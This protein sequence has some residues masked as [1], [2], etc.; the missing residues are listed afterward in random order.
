[1]GTLFLDEVAELPFHLQ[2]K[3]LRVLQEHSFERLGSVRPIEFTA[4]IVA[5]S[6]RNL[7]DEVSAGNFREDLYHRLNLAS[8]PVPALRERENDIELL[9]AHFLNQANQEIGKSVAGIELDVVARLNAY[10]WPGNVRELEH[11]IKRAVLAARG[12]TVTLHE[13]DLPEERERSASIN[14]DLQQSLRAQAVEMVADPGKF[15]GSGHVY[16][17]LMDAAGLELIHAALKS[18]NGNQV[19]AAK[20]LG[21]NRSTLRKKLSDAE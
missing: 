8:L 20:L 19:A 16:Q 12:T 9:M 17:H 1:M 14:V 5:A 13:L 7:E 2:S 6:N 11:C 18:T 10:S 15:G 21:I 4:R 3:L